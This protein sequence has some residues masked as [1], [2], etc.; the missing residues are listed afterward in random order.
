M[1]TTYTKSYCPYCHKAKA[2]LESL[3]IEYN[4]IDV[5]DDPEKLAEVSKKTG[6]STVPQIFAGDNFLGGC[7]DVHR[8]HDEGKLVELCK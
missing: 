6:V 2:L 1:V 7:D 5:T 8:L 4:D 3:N